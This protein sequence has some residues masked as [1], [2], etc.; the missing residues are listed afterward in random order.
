[1]GV[2]LNLALFFAYHVFWPA[3]FAQGFDGFSACIAVLAAVALF[4]FKTGV[5]PL[6]AICG[7]LGLLGTVLPHWAPAWLRF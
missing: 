7:G 5:L 2:I 4:R 3:G 1:V 6:L